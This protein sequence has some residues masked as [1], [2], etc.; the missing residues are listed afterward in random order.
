MV[1]NLDVATRDLL[2]S[3]IPVSMKVPSK[4]IPRKESV[5]VLKWLEKKNPAIRTSSWDV[6][7]V[8]RTLALCASAS[9]LGC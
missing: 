6:Y 5:A 8:S 4:N 2:I 7:G 9:I 3:Q 1:E